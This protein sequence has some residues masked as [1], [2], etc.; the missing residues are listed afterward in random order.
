MEPVDSPIDPV[1]HL[2]L[3]RS[4]GEGGLGPAPHGLEVSVHADAAGPGQGMLTVFSASG[5][6]LAQTAFD[7]SITVSVHAA[8]NDL[9]LVLEMEG[10]RCLAARVADYRSGTA[11]VLSPLSTLVDAYA[12]NHPGIGLAQAQAQVLESL[13][14]PPDLP[15]GTLGC[16]VDRNLFD[17]ERFYQAV[18]V[19][20]GVDSLARQMAEAV[21]GARAKDGV[22]GT[23]SLPGAG[24]STEA[25]IK[26]LVDGLAGNFQGWAG[27]KIKGWL[28]NLSGINGFM[29]E[30][31][32][33]EGENTTAKQ[34]EAL[35]AEIQRLSEA[36]KS[37]PRSQAY[38][39]R[40]TALETLRAAVKA[41]TETL[42]DA[43]GDAPLSAKQL[44]E[45]FVKPVNDSLMLT[46]LHN[47]Q[48]GS[49][50]DAKG[51][52]RLLLDDHHKFYS[53]HADT[54]YDSILFNAFNQ[55][56]ALQAQAL[57]LKIEAAHA[58]NPPQ[59]DAAERYLDQYHVQIKRQRLMY[60]NGLKPFADG[61]ILD[62][63]TGL[64]WRSDM[65]EYDGLE[66]LMADPASAGNPWRLPTIEELQSLKP[67]ASV[68]ARLP[69]S[70][71][72]SPPPAIMR[73]FGFS[74]VAVQDK[75]TKQYR[76]F[77]DLGPAGSRPYKILGPGYIV[78]S[79]A[80]KRRDR[81]WGMHDY[82]LRTLVMNL[83][84]ND[85]E[86]IRIKFCRGDGRCT[87]Q[88][89][90]NQP[91]QPWTMPVLYVRSPA[92]PAEFKVEFYEGFKPTADTA[93]G[94]AWVRYSDSTHWKDVT[95]DVIW[96]VVGDNLLDV[97]VSN[98]DGTSGLVQLR[99]KE[100][101]PRAYTIKAEFPWYLSD[102]PGQSGQLE[103]TAV[104]YGN[105]DAPLPVLKRLLLSPA[106][107]DT[108]KY[109]FSY[110]LHIRGVM[111]S[112][113]VVDQ[114]TAAWSCVPAEAGVEISGAGMVTVTRSP[115][116]TTA[117]RITA[118]IGGAEGSA[119]L[120]LLPDK[121]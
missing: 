22:L 101:K 12:A 37:L 64:L 8:E 16:S 109:P 40:L 10:G 97:H 104:L 32:L 90:V 18:D 52:I 80:Y 91:P 79:N 42:Q 43:A 113:A 98:G 5:E 93:Q 11:V 56:S 29:S 83:Y 57:N 105:Q 69:S 2:D 76:H 116:S 7:R 81:N 53:G 65:F 50:A 84:N 88:Y 68:T 59:I 75:G 62:R 55:A 60:P 26:E 70:E 6:T 44:Y 63:D 86:S 102:R 14:L 87:T 35:T 118:R 74:P 85:Q 36:I 24:K 46:E 112:G 54:A 92:V 49:G 96:S 20:G 66:R 111:N 31:G 115:A 21:P 47:N 120:V 28:I 95:Q 34:L 9:R 45:E 119:Y 72:S 39:A 110:S 71:S 38:L 27:G 73:H 121:T 23:A 107:K 61:S 48:V 78:S 30:L 1:V 4:C 99:S 58:S 108:K 67:P 114:E 13:A 51:L 41:K 15:V 3:V 100:R 77:A 103:A 89:G 94:W 33:S 19:A 117:V 17:T 25:A 106:T 82:E